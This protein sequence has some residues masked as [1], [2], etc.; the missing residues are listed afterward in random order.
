[1]SIVVTGTAGFIGYHVSKALLKR[2]EQVVG[3]DNLNEYYDPNLK[4]ARLA[5]LQRHNAFC[6]H[7]LDVS[8]R[9]ALPALFE[10]TPEIDQVVHLAAQAGVRYSLVNPF[11]YVDA[12]IMGQIVVQEACRRLPRF[13][14]LV[15]ASSSSVYG[16]NDK[17]PFST[18]D[19]VDNPIS[20]YAATK[21]AAELI[22][23][24]YGQIYRM[25]MTGLRFFTVYGPWGRPDMAAYIFTKAI[26]EGQPI[27]IFNQGHMKRDFT[28]VEDIVSGVIAALERPPA[29]NGTAPPQ[30]IY[31]LGNHRAEDLTHFIAIIEAACG[32]RALREFTDMQ[33][34]D[35]KETYADIEP[36]RRDLG[37]EPKT[38]IEEGLPRFVSWFREYH[39]I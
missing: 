35:V 37:F 23:N 26:L 31:N 33:L 34:G 14:H 29:D 19:R 39:G 30:G 1:M 38:T 25:P 18:E 3:I 2:G 6:F 28:Y 27:K 22:A 13:R 11:V 21:R 7:Q 17:M 12:N 20:L 32:R 9:D 4:R 24:C 36:A 15:Y 10:Q 5:E 16:G 8:D